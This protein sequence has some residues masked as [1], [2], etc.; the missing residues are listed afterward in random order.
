[1]FTQ[2]TYYVLVLKTFY[3]FILYKLILMNYDA[4][5]AQ[6]DSVWLYDGCG[7]DMHSG[8]I[9]LLLTFFLSNKEWHKYYNEL[10]F[11]HILII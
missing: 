3:P 5:V 4:I 7:F 10:V 6:W 8:I 11:N 2:L 1:M 9:C